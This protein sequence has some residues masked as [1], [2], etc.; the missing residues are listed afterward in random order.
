MSDSNNSKALARLEALFDDGAFT[1]LDAYAKSA[2]GEVEVVAGFG[3]VNECPVYAFSQDI[4]VGDG[5]VSV[6][7]CA[8]IKK[9][10]DLASK[11]GC[12]VVSIF[13]SNG[14]KLTEGFEVLSAY[15]EL[16]KASSS[17]SGVCP[18]IAVIAGACLGTS[19]LIA[20]MAD[21]V[22]AVKD[23]DFYL[24]APSSI[25]AED[26]Y[27]EGTVDVLAD[28]FNA[29]V[30]AVGDLIS[31]LPANNLSS[32]PMFDFAAPQTVAAEGADALSIIASIAD[33]AS[34]VEL[35]GGYASSNCKTA[36]ASVMGTTVGF[37]G[38]EGNALCPAC[39]YKAEA[40][41]KLCDAYSI[42]VVTLVNADGVIHEK[43]NQALI[44]MT[45]L[46][47]AYAGATCPKVSVI[48]GK[49][50]GASYVTLAGKGANA[51]MTIAWDCAVASP[52]DADAAVAFLFNDRLADGEDREALKKEYIDTIASPFTAA[53]CGAVDD[54][55]SPADTRAKVIAALDILA[56]KRET[57]LPRKHSVK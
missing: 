44:A 1:Q 25:T 45:K 6:A 38:F 27:K 57:T 52:L 42:P 47:S 53:A 8:K 29:A 43:E 12:P 33:D 19:A 22:V 17:I 55:C 56:G 9:I 24:S 35:K 10:Y 16:V 39:A 37:V 51:D 18:Q 50:I 2:D 5:A 41:V 54:I 20:D 31:L 26:S 21:V 40:M 36:L 23:A 7:Q 15:G 48:T 28:D 11:T 32:A 30:E 4:T 14:V 34:V 49:A 13:D 46:I 3:T